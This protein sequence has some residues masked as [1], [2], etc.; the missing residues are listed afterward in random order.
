M[1]PN[2]AL[3]PALS[4]LLPAEALRGQIERAVLI[5]NALERYWHRPVRAAE[6]RAELHRI[7]RDSRDP[8]RLEEIVAA[9][10]GDGYRLAECL[11]RPLLVERM[12]RA[13][14]ADDERFG[15]GADPEQR[16]SFDEWLESVRPGLSLQLVTEPAA[17]AGWEAPSVSTSGASTGDDR[18]W[19]TAAL[20]EATQGE[21]AVWTGT[22]MIIWGGGGRN[23]G[24]RYDPATD[25][26]TPTAMVGAP[27]PRTP[28][29]RRCGPARR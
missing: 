1:L 8:E 28:P 22:E 10:N 14:Y 11:A 25:T 21:T 7:F 24:S 9:L 18:W 19:P 27:A 5:S 13:F 15:A 2:P 4:E 26:W 12:A 23:T 20:P 16:P 17:W 29:H 3:K 6:L